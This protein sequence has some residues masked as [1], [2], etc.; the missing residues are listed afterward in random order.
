MRYKGFC[1]LASSLGILVTAMPAWG[2]HSFAAVFDKDKVIA[3]EA[4]VSVVKWEN[5]HTLIYVEAKDPGGKEVQ[6][7]FESLPPGVLFR[8]GL[9]RDRLKPGAQVTM[10]GHLARD[11][12]NFAEVSEI[13]FSDGQSFCV[14]AS[15]VS[16]ICEATGQYR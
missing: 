1:G 2:H 7:T 6:W 13:L 9:R 16:Y 5:P 10:K 12:S 3:V 4:V 11:G 8:K 14:P 15:L